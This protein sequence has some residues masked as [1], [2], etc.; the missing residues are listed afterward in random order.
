[1]TTTTW[2][3]PPLAPLAQPRRTRARSGV[4]PTLWLGVL[5]VLVFWWTGTAAPTGG[6][7]G[8]ALMS[9]GELA[10]VLTSA[11]ATAAALLAIGLAP[12][13]ADDRAEQVASAQPQ[14]T[15]PTAV[16][17]SA[18][19]SGKSATATRTPTGATSTRAASTRRRSSRR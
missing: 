18:A 17:S 4:L 6:T 12:V 10:G 1:M 13:L 19:P 8:G 11:A 5:A 9:L 16:P 14:V 3:A 7:P 2:E 15:A